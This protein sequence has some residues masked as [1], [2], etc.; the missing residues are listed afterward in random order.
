[1]KLCIYQQFNH[2]GCVSFL[3]IISQLTKFV[4]YISILIILATLA[5]VAHP[6][7]G[8]VSGPINDKIGR[9]KAIM[10]VNIPL[11][12]SWIILGFSH[13][14]PLICLLFTLVGFCFGLMEAP[15]LTYV[16]E[17]RLG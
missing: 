16:S 6:I 1:M 15:T 3:F 4:K 10:L 17:I 2:R 14:F 9:R 12:M 13:S 7:G 8:V 5:H 11:T